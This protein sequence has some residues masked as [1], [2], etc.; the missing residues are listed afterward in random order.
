MKWT[1]AVPGGVQI[2]VPNRE[3]LLPSVNNQRA[4]AQ[5][6]SQVSGHDQD[7]LTLVA[8][9]IVFKHVCTQHLCTPNGPLR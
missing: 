9:N 3:I 1:A 4:V 7:L 5:Q 6:T 2:P 8:R